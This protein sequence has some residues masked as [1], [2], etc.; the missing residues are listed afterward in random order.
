[1]DLII[2]FNC[3]HFSI[4]LGVALLIGFLMMVQSRNFYTMHVVLRK[5]SM[6]DLQFP[7]SPLELVHY[8]KGIFLLPEPATRKVVKNL[9]GQL[10]IDF[11]FMIAAYGAIFILCMKVSLKMEWIG[12]WIFA[13]FAW[14]QL[15]PLLCDTIEN[16]YLIKKIKPN[17]APSS[18]AV[19]KLMQRVELVKWIIPLTAIVCCLAAMAYCWITGNYSYNSMEYLVLVIAEIALFIILIKATSKDEKEKI[20]EFTSP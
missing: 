9:R 7:A 12:Q 1:M 17:P 11:I 2:Q 15:V 18:K 5:F 16:I 8:I 20:K 14:L 6:I 19:H 10:Y 13:I 3:M 4:A